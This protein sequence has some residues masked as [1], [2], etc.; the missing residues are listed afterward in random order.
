M[1]VSP[2]PVVRSELP[3]LILK[4]VIDFEVSFLHYE[5]VLNRIKSL[6]IV[7]RLESLEILNGQASNCNGLFG[8]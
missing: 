4:G 1:L 6:V 7:S 5:S 8:K 3:L 2:K